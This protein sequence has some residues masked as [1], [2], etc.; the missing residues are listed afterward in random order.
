M[1]MNNLMDKTLVEYQ[2]STS[3]VEYLKLVLEIQIKME[4]SFVNFNKNSTKKFQ[5]N[6]ARL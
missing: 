5:R 1:K 2:Q 3:L 4:F 6:Q